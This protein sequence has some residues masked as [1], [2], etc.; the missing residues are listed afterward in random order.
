MRWPSGA[1]VCCNCALKRALMLNTVWVDFSWYLTYNEN[2]SLLP[3]TRRSISR[4]LIG[5]FQS[6]DC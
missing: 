4:Q 6:I 3:G 1:S 5:N 2:L